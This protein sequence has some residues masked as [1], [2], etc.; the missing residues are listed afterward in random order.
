MAALRY[1]LEGAYPF[2]NGPVVAVGETIG[3]TLPF[4]REGIGKAMESGQLAAE[5]ISRALDSDDLNKL[6]QY[7][8]QIESEIKARDQGYRKAEKWLAKPRL[9]DFLLS[10]FGKSKYA[11]DILAGVIA[12]TKN[13]KDIFSLKGIMKSFWR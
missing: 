5:A 8:R 4:I 2:V 11:K 13:S 12:E 3:T 10:R 1:N 7:N 6:S 9:N